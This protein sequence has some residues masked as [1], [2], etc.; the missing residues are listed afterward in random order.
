MFNRFNIE[1]ITMHK[2]VVP[3]AVQH[4]LSVMAL[5]N[6]IS[7]GFAASNAAEH[8]SGKNRVTALTAGS[9]G[10]NYGSQKVTVSGSYAS[11]LATA[12]PNLR[13]S[14][15]TGSDKNPANN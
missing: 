13:A 10:S 15:T 3:T 5:P 7:S 4:T 1:V 9:I 11:C 2:K 12:L 14:K 8:L 6:S